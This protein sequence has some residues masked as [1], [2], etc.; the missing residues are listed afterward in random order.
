VL[1][2]HDNDSL[3]LSALNAFDKLQCAKNYIDWKT[4][5]RTMLMSLRQWGMNDG[6]IARPVLVGADNVTADET[7]AMQEWDFR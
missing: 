7:A 4:N 3:I 2:N 1:P 5:M 6:S